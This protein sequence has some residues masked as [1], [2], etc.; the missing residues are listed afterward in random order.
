LVPRD[1][2]GRLVHLNESRSISGLLNL[3]A[4][5]DALKEFLEVLFAD[6]VRVN[7]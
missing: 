6:S 5:I 1:L 3:Q 7:S 2:R 4:F